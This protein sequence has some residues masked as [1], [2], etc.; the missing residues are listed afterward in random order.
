MNVD[1]GATILELAGIPNAWPGGGGVRDGTSLVPVLHAPDGATPP[2]WRTRTLLEFVGW[3]NPYEWLQPC[4]WG[5]APGTP[6]GPNAP[7][8][9]INAAS[10]RWSALRVDN[11]TTRT[12]VADFRPPQA[13]LARASTN[14]TEAYNL[15]ADPE[16]MV[17]VA[18]RGRLSPVTLDAM[19]TEL[20]ELAACVGAQCP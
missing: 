7:A 12:L 11:A 13:P 15:A 19:R 20:W 8:G 17:N 18:V 6:C 1:L 9:L 16:A 5:L 10:N 14:F 3:I 2:G 4:T